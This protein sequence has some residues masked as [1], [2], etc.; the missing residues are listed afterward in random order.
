MKITF[1]NSQLSYSWHAK[2]N[3]AF[4]AYV[5]SICFFFTVVPTASKD[6]SGKIGA[7]PSPEFEGII[8]LEEITEKYSAHQISKF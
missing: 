5:Y 7:H 8:D 1:F 4:V 3:R 6:T 2:E